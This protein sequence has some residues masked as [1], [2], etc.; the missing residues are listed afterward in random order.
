MLGERS[1]RRRSSPT[2][3]SLCPDALSRQ[4]KLKERELRKLSERVEKLREERQ[5]LS[6]EA[7]QLRDHNYSL[8]SEIN[9][10]A[11]EKSA[12]LLANRDLQIEVS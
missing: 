4:Q 2:G 1:S 6:E 5:L 9:G 7:K 3:D 12:A 11:Q 10:L 8:M